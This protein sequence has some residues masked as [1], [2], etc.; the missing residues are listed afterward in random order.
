MGA[1]AGSA[2]CGMLRDNPPYTWPFY[3]LL[4]P[5][6]F[7]VERKMLLEIRSRAKGMPSADL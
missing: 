3:L 2:C 6:A 5:G 1:G 4:E 7:V